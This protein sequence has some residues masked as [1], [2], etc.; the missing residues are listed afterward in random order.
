MSATWKAMPSFAFSL[1]NRPGELARFARELADAGINIVGLWGYA[2]GQDEPRLSCVPEDA[3][4][5]KAFAS[6]AGLDLEADH[7]LYM[8]GESTAGALVETLQAIAEAGINLDAI[9]AV[10]SGPRFGCFIW[11]SASDRERLQKLLK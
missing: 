4:A 8:S 2:P 1:P 11:A 7:A 10:G 3:D 6:K 9:E 5:F